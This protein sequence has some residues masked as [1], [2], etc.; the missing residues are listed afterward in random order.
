MNRIN[1]LK[2]C[3]RLNIKRSY[4]S[5]VVTHG[6]LRSRLEKTTKQKDP[7]IQS[8]E[9]AHNYLRKNSQFIAT[10]DPLGLREREDGIMST[11]F[12]E[13]S[14]QEAEHLKNTYC[15]NVAFDLEHLNDE[16]EKAWLYHQIENSSFELTKEKQ[17]EICAHLLKSQVFEN[18][19]A[20]RFPTLKRYS[21]E[22]AESMLAMFEELFHIS[23]KSG[24]NEVMI[25]IPHR[26][27]LALLTG[28]LN[29]P[30]KALFSKLKGNPEFHSSLRF[31]GDVSSHLTSS[32]DLNYNDKNIHV[33]M[34]PNPSHLEASHP[35]IMGKA[36]SRF[37]TKQQAY[38]NGENENSEDELLNILSIQVHGDAAMA[39]QGIVMETFALASLPHFEVGGSVHLV[40][41]NQLGFTTPHERAST[42]GHSSDIA[43]MISAPIIHVNGDSPE[44]V[45]KVTKL[46]VDYRNKFKKDVVINML[47]FRRWGHNELDD[48]TFTNPA[49]YDVIHQR[50]SVPDLYKKKLIQDG[51]VTETEIESIE[52]EYYALLDEQLKD[53][54]RQVEPAWKPFEDNWK[55]IQQASHQSASTWDTGCDI[56]LLKFVGARS[57]CFPDQFNIHQHLEKTFC[58]ARMKKIESGENID[59]ATAEALA[60]G[61]LLMQGHHVRISGQDVGRGTFSH[62]HS[63]LVDQK[64]NE[65]YIPLNH[66][67]KQQSGC[68]EVVNSLLSEEAVLAY[69]YGMSIENPKHLVIWEAQFGDFF[70]GAQI[71]I[72]TYIANAEAKWLLQ[73]G[74]VMLLP[75]GMDGAGPDHSSSKIERFL[76]MSD[77]KEDG[78]DSDDV[79][80]QIVNPTTAA[81]YFH[82]LRRQQ[83]RNFRKPLIVASPKLIL[84]MSA[85]SSTLS[86]LV[87]G[88]HFK[89]VIGD[90]SPDMDK[91]DTVVFCSG[92]HYYELAKQRTKQSK[93]N[94]AIVRLD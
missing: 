22:G 34:V 3:Y 55:G 71:I 11:I 84:R 20:K 79:N 16:D 59:W 83:I 6:V 36:R 10:V 15:Q 64:N 4:Q 7:V 60:I 78:V 49:M 87:P 43:K 8:K 28:M 93:Q 29:Y 82:L 73:S 80:M 67:S 66:M 63:M 18:F 25:S 5:Q 91:I 90:S 54:D 9:D 65:L 46:A 45:A 30:N 24:T 85:A 92:K 38:Y 51:V 86:D 69:E 12:N 47:C 48:P 62:R 56:D 40:V 94:V 32:T 39:G 2:R 57:T 81:Q 68:L 19:L 44:D 77:S 17:K 50:E 61:S 13:F 14:S 41:N 27:R 70:N 37:L 53:A 23:S 75:H 21:G 33:T 74:L 42:A 58:E 26:G 35:V 72:D 52:S 88:T 31:I 1:Y 89:P 76:Q